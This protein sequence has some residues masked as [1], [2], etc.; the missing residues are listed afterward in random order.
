MY[1]PE[2]RYSIRSDIA[3][4]KLLSSY[5]LS[6]AISG[7]ATES[8]RGVEAE[9]H[10][11]LARHQPATQSNSVLVPWAILARANTVAVAS[12]GG[13][14]VETVNLTAADALRP[15]LV[16]GPLGQ[17]IITAPA[18][19]NVNLP[20]QTAAGTAYWLSTESSTA[21]ESD[22]TFGQ[23]S[24]VPHTVG[25]YTELSRLLRLQSREADA[26]ISRD[27]AAVLSRAIDK[28]ELCGNGLLGSL[29]G[30]VSAAGVGT[31]SAASTVLG[32]LIDAEV[33]LGDAV[34]P[35]TAVV[36]TLSVAGALRKRAEISGGAA[37][38]MWEG[39]LTAGTCA[40]MPA[41]SSTSINAGT[42]ILG[43]FEYLNLVVWGDLEI[44]VN[45]YASF[46]SGILGIRAFCTV[47]SGVTWPS[48]FTIGT[49]FS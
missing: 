30:I 22:Q 17:T 4:Q 15:R 45:P 34:G 8:R 44:A 32:T 46:R 29:N 13:Y 3:W 27:L 39:P 14:L 43:T 9:V 35:T 42:L 49:S 41:R 21:T 1:T 36:T 10:A 47:D 19:A 40:S 37:R 6:E 20:R 12:Q 18:G 2:Q 33:A 25:A 11:E 7:L 26:I 28:A 31:F 23:V 24:F 48:A 38:V 5:S 16:A